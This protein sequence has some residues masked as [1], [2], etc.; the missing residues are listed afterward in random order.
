MAEGPYAT[1]YRAQ[2]LEM[3]IQYTLVQ[4]LNTILLTSML[5]KEHSKTIAEIKGSHVW[6]DVSVRAMP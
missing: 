5:R 3:D 6:D 2:V 1:L 4:C